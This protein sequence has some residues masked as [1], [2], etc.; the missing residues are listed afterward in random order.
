M[1]PRPRLALLAGLGLAALAPPASAAPISLRA[2]R[3]VE[4]SDCATTALAG[5]PGVA[6]VSY[7]VPAL[8]YVTARLNGPAGSDWDLGVFDHA[9]GRSLGGSANWD[10]SE[11][12]Q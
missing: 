9:T 7:T 6:R 11:V 5:A 8:G 12:V 3:A 10:A 1:S 4:R 2:A